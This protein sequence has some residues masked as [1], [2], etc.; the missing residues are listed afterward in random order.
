MLLSNTENIGRPY[1]VLS[2]VTGCSVLCKNIGRDIVSSFKNLVG[3]EMKAYAEMLDNSQVLAVQKMMARAESMGADAVVNIRF[4]SSSIVQGGAEIL[5]SG[6]A[7]KF[8][9]AEYS[10][11]EWCETKTDRSVKTG[12]EKWEQKNRTKTEQKQK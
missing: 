4:S 11:N 6:T 1:E 3:G 8:K 2:L 7:V 9:Q 10:K 5:A 12:T